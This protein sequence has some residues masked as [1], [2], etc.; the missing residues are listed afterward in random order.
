MRLGSC[1]VLASLFVTLVARTPSRA[2][3]VGL[4]DGLVRT[5]LG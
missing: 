2:R 5:R 4:V 1:M 3:T